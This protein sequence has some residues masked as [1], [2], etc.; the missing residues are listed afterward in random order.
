MTEEEVQGALHAQLRQSPGQ[1]KQVIDY[2]REQP[3]ASQSLRAPIFEEKVVDYI[4]E[5]AEVTDKPVSKEELL[6]EEDDDQEAII[7]TTTR[8]RPRSRHHGHDHDH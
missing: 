4:L 5:F 2:Y 8:Q 3:G 6:A 7:T 1:E